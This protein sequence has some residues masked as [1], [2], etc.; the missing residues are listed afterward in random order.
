MPQ[1]P[2]KGPQGTNAGSK[3]RGGQKATYGSTVSPEVSSEQAEAIV[4]DDT[5]SDQAD[6][7]P[8]STGRET[9]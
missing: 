8:G 6:S 3:N 7:E 4:G 2:S 5:V 1:R 9:R